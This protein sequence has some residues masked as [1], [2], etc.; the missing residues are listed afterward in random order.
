MLSMLEVK[1]GCVG[2]SFCLDVEDGD[3]AIV[4]ILDSEIVRRFSDFEFR[5]TDKRTQ[6]QNHN[7]TKISWHRTGGGSVCDAFFLNGYWQVV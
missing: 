7:A 3:G 5:V 1:L 6:I 4:Q 2:S